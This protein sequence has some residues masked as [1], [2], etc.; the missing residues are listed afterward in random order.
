MK[1]GKIMKM[2]KKEKKVTSRKLAKKMGIKMDVASGHLGHLFKKGL[3][4]R[5]PEKTQNNLLRYRY[6]L[7]DK[8]KKMFEKFGSYEKYATKRSMAN[9]LQFNFKKKPKKL[10]E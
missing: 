1:L 3:L 4:N 5:E 9:I 2:V 8:G 6:S 7:S 10:L